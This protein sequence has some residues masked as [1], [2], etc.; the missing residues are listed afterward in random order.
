MSRAP[1][2]RSPLKSFDPILGVLLREGAKAEQRI[3]CGTRTEATAF[4][5]QVN[6]YR[7]AAQAE[8]A[9][10]WELL[11]AAEVRKDTKDD[12][13]V[14]VAPKNSSA[15]KRIEAIGIKI[16]PSAETLPPPPGAPKEKEDLK[17]AFLKQM[18]E[19]LENLDKLQKRS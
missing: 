15:R 12:S 13:V 8:N 9:P 16:D 2:K 18:Q 1:R 3:P 6:T 11:F 17:E 14:I 5:Y 4:R 7:Q 19:E 10:G